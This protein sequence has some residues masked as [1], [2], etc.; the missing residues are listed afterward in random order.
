MAEISKEDVLK[1]AEVA[2][3]AITD[4]EATMYSTQ[5]T[6][7]VT[8][9]EKIFDV[10]TDGVK[11]TTNGNIITNVLRNDEPVRWDKREEA[12]QNAPDK[13]DGQFK[14]PAILD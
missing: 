4:E 10:D 2:R 9:T 3:L 14:V 12:L 6:K 5:L 8:Y 1:T 13:E 7:I 11:P